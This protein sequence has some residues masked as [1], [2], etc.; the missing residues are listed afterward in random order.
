M[1]KFHFDVGVAL[2]LLRNA[3]E[4]ALASVSPNDEDLR[5]EPINWNDLSVVDV[6][7]C[8]DLDSD[9][10]I[11]VLIEE[12]APD[13]CPNFVAA[14]RRHMRASGVLPEKAFL[15]VQTRW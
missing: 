11:T 13:E 9:M 8:V 7:L 10:V 15:E 5:L 4:A 1:T 2:E 6:R 3:A 12:A 14:I